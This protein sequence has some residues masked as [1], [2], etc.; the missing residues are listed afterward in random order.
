MINVTEEEQPREMIPVSESSPAGMFSLAVSKGLDLD[1][2]KKMMELQ[3]TWDENQAKKAFFDD[4]AKA[5]TEM[6]P[7]P[8]DMKNK[9]YNDAPY[10]SLGKLMEICNPALGKYGF[11]TRHEY[12]R[13]GDQQTC[14]C[15]LSHKLAHSE[16]VTEKGP[17]DKSGSKNPIQER[18][19]TIT[20]LRAITYEGVTGVSGTSDAN[21]NDDGNSSGSG[22][23]SL[24][25]Q[26]E[27]KL[28][29][30]IEAST[31]SQDYIDWWAKNVDQINKDLK[32][33]Q[34]AKIHSIV[35]KNK[36]RLEP[37]EREPGE[38]G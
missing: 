3:F 6:P 38:E 37:K 23:P 20:Y 31:N 9:Q 17:P 35:V 16:S 33:P 15:I 1:Q 30:L 10:T 19:S 8:K 34:A 32:K 18:K 5:K 4:L 7:I 26:W 2:V 11:S 14:T 36:K 21:L 28:N 27:A 25:E 24:Y 13:D 29:E 12:G 22:E